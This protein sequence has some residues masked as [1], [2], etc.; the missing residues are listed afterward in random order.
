VQDV[1]NITVFVFLTSFGTVVILEMSSDLDMAAVAYVSSVEAFLSYDG[2]TQFAP[3]IYRSVE[4]FD[5]SISEKEK[6][7]DC[8]YFRYD[9]KNGML[10]YT[11]ELFNL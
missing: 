3:S 2:S 5:V 11:A 4:P 6:I 10:K 7:V 1:D 9:Y 8:K